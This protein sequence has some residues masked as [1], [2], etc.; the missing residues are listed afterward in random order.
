MSMDP[1][2][3]QMEVSSSPMA[4]TCFGTRLHLTSLIVR[5]RDRNSTEDNP[6]S[7]FA[8]ARPSVERFPW[9]AP[10]PRAMSRGQ[11]TKN[12]DVFHPSNRWKILCNN[13]PKM[14]KTPLKKYEQPTPGLPRVHSP[15]ASCLQQTPYSTH[16]CSGDRIP[17]NVGK[18][19]SF[20]FLLGALEF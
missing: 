10:T 3:R 13:S 7:S 11:P 12:R 6:N 2:F 4:L 5:R 15:K 14:F 17:P 1:R 19:G 8:Q 20:L 16:D 9:V 18:A